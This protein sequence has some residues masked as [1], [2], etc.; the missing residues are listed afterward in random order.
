MNQVP[1]GNLPLLELGTSISNRDRGLPCLAAAESKN[2]G[3]PI[4]IKAVPPRTVA[5]T[6][7]KP[8]TFYSQS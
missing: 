1:G 6:H 2:P 8:F 4:S 7:S 3:D 5:L